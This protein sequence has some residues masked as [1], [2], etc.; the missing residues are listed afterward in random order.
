[1]QKK[2]AFILGTAFLIH[3]CN[4]QQTQNNN[5]F[6]LFG[7][8]RSPANMNQSP[9]TPLPNQPQ[10]QTQT[11]P[12]VFTNAPPAPAPFIAPPVP[13]PQLSI[14]QKPVDQVRLLAPEPVRKH[15]SPEPPLATGNSNIPLGIPAGP[16]GDVPGYQILNTSLALGFMPYPDGIDWL[17][18]NKFKKAVFVTFPGQET[19]VVESLFARKGLP[20]ETREL[21]FNQPD[22]AGFQ[23][24]FDSIFSSLDKPIYLFDTDGSATSPLVYH[25]LVSQKR[26]NDEQALNFLQQHGMLL[27]Q[28]EKSRQF[29]KI[30]RTWNLKQS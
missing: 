12:P 4:H 19:K 9:P 20:L 27:N 26:M 11:Q 5:S 2:Y 3:G 17:G 8:L 14:S 21:N 29:L 22:K 30:V 25:Y 6:K 18:Q 13:Q 15:L 10:F 24:L 7:K 16:T 1:M 28:N 23:S